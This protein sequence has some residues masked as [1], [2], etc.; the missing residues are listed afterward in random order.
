MK[1][2]PRALLKWLLVAILPDNAQPVI[3]T[4]WST[5]IASRSIRSGRTFLHESNGCLGAR[6]VTR[7]SIAD[8]I[9]TMSDISVRRRWRGDAARRYF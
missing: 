4:V 2:R 1:G 9:S 7:S 5:H 3:G 8:P 6:K